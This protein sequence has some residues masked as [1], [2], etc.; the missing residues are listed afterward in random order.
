MEETVDQF[1]SF[2]RDIK[3]VSENT[4]VSYKRDLLKMQDY[5]LKQG[6]ESEDKITATGMNTYILWLEK[7]GCASATISRYI[8]SMKSYFH[9]LLQTGK[10]SSDPAMLLKNPII[11]KREPRVLTVSQIDLLL[12]MPS[13]DSNKEI[14][15]KAMLELMYATGIRVSELI[16]LHL[17]DVNLQTGYIVVGKDKAKE[18]IIPIGDSARRAVYRYLTEARDALL[19]ERV[20]EL[21]FVNCSGKN[22]SRQGFWKIIKSYGRQA[23]IEDE[24][25]PQM[26]RHT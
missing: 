13:G 7:S 3:N 6:I 12:S 1:I 16:S 19:K 20:S 18:R 17:D 23:G 24:I 8:A 10:I 21:M 11:E 5:F 4:A 22:M 26:L 25:T 15:D 14:R 2:L 9:Y